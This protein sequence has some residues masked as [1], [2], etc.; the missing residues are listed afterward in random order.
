MSSKDYRELP[1]LIPQ[2]IID[3]FRRL[4]PAQL[5]DGMKGLGILSDGCMDSEIMPVDEKKV[6]IGTACTVDT[7]DGDNFPIHVALSQGKPGYVMIIAGKAHKNRAYMGD[8]MGA[9]AEAVGLNGIVVDGFVRDKFG[10]RDLEVPIYSRGFMQRGPSKKGP[11]KINTEVFCAGVIV[12]P[13]DLV[14]GDYDGVTVVPRDMIDAVLEKAEKKDAYEVQRRKTI[15]EYVDCV[16]KGK[17][18]PEIA[19]AW[20]KDMLNKSEN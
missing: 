7:E 16:K 14:V 19:P 10:L 20:V 17:E 4:S 2:D 15:G 18:P 13:G 6:M 8:L 5:C 3:R 12:R 11:G 1:Q 9:T